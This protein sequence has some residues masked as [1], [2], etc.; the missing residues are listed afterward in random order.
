MHWLWHTSYGKWLGLT[1][2]L[3]YVKHD[4]DVK[5][6]GKYFMK[7]FCINIMAYQRICAYS[8][9]HKIEF[10]GKGNEYKIMLLSFY[11]KNVGLQFYC[12]IHMWN[13]YCN[14]LKYCIKLCEFIVLTIIKL[15]SLCNY[16]CTKCSCGS[17][18][19]T[20]PHHLFS[21][22]SVYILRLSSAL[23]IIHYRQYWC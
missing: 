3:E 21:N 18:V 23:K 13:I 2:G 11:H 7:I 1:T 19:Q 5:V 12:W 8:I 14:N 16:T 10:N 20:I 6:N 4:D 17:S 15:G 22:T 9:L